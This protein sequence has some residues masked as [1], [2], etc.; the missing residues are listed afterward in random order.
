MT[1]NAS[2]TAIGD[3]LRSARQEAG[4]S[5]DDVIIELA[6]RGVTGPM[7]M[8]RAKIN[9]IEQGYRKLIDPIAVATLAKVYNKPL[10][11]ISP[12]AAEMLARWWGFVGMPDGDSPGS[13][14]T[15]P[16]LQRAA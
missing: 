1:N 6:T 13:P 8:S 15:P 12:E 2:L 14:C 10:E 16:V 3:R 5:L 4:M 7:G 9:Q 11:E